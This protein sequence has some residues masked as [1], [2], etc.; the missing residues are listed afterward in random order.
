MLWRYGKC[1]EYYKINKFLK[2]P[3]DFAEKKR[4]NLRKS[5][6]SAGENKQR[7]AE[8]IRLKSA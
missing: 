7:Y 1:G 6:K 2:V 5:A 8:K 3:A 4:L